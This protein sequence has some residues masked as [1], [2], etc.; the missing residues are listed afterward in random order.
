MWVKTGMGFGLLILGIFIASRIVPVI[1]GPQISIDTLPQNSEVS[2]PMISLT[3]TATD[4][5]KLTINGT[6]VLLSPAGEF[7]QKV[8][9]HPGYNTITFD[10]SDNLGHTKKKSFA[11]L[12]KELDS[13]TFA[14]SSLPDQN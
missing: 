2:D 14:L 4:T 1:R 8:L 3:G 10:S 5:K 11:F 13:G 9:L 7:N 12:L 6:E